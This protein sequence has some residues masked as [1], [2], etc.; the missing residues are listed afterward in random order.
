MSAAAF[1]QNDGY[2]HLQLV[3]QDKFGIVLGD[4]RRSRISSRLKPVIDEFLTNDLHGLADRLSD[5]KSVK[6]RNAVLLAIT[7]YSTVWFEPAEIFTLLAEYVLPG[8]MDKHNARIWIIGC[9]NGALPYSVSMA[10]TEA[11]KQSGRKLSVEIVTTDI[12]ESIL[13]KA[14]QAVYDQSS[15]RNLDENRMHKFMTA[16]SGSRRV[17]DDIHSRLTFTTC[18]LLDDFTDMGHFDVVICLDTLMYFSVALRSQ[19]LDGI[20]RLLAPSGILLVGANETVIPL[21][22]DFERVEID[23]GVFYRQKS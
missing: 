4:E 10:V 11:Q 22:R 9:G 1:E 23:S 12:A 20:A 14:R 17:N 19:I 7:S 6:L 15:L 5:E 2:Q 18:N 21:C 8:L 13:T 3:L 16:E